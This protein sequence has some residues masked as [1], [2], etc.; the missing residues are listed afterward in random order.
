MKIIFFG[1]SD[2]A[3]PAL[4]ALHHEGYTVVTVITVPDK[5]AGRKKILT[6]PSVKIAAQKLELPVLQPKS[7]KVDEFEN[8]LEIRNL[9]LEVDSAALGIVASYGKIIPGYLLNKFKKGLLNIHPS[10]LPKYRGPS[11]IQSAILNGEE[12]TGVTLM[13]VDKEVDHGPIL[14]RAE[15]KIP[16]LKYYE[17]IKESLAE[18]GAKLLIETLPNYLNGTVKPREQDHSR[19][20]LTKKLVWADGKIN[21]RQSAYEI[22]DQ[23]RALHPEP[24]A[25]TIKKDTPNETLKI[26]KASPLAQTVPSSPGVALIKNR[27]ILVVTGKGLLK[28]EEVQPSG[29]K[30][31]SAESFLHGLGSLPQ[32]TF[33]VEVLKKI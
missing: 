18:L 8:Y 3:V 4:K 9:K 6:P 33:L 23:I 31:M 27:A 24:G 20:T 26:L 12:K 28:L 10:L 22:F 2:F 11:P 14:N 15:F 5:P 17:E 32:L 30:A 21:W 1:T 29:K 16:S 7:L 19:A 13:L 25:W